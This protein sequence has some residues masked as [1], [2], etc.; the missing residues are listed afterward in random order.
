MCSTNGTK[1]KA[2]RILEGKPEIKRPLRTPTYKWVNN[3]KMYLI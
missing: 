1:R 2:C 3:I